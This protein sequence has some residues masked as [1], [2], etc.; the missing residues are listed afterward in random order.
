M[1]PSSDFGDHPMLRATFK[2]IRWLG[3]TVLTPRG[4]TEKSADVQRRID[5]GRL[6]VTVT[7]SGRKDELV[8]TT[9]PNGGISALRITRTVDGETVTENLNL[10]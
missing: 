3:L 4:S 8:V 2:G 7:R 9:A 6:F 5:G 10:K 1:F